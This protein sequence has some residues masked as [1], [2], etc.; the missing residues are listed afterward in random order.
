MIKYLNHLHINYSDTFPCA[1]LL[2][3]YRAHRTDDV[4]EEVRKLGIKLIY[5]PSNGTGKYQPLDRR[6]FWILKSKLRS[7]AKS[8]I[9]SVDDLFASITNHLILAWDQITKFEVSLRI[10]SDNSFFN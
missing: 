1:L 2:D 8:E 4:K 5:V 10:F 6:I 9:F 7:L 3:C